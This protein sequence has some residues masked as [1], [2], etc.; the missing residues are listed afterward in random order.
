MAAYE[1]DISCTSLVGSNLVG[2]EHRVVDWTGNLTSSNTQVPCGVVR[3]GKAANKASEIIYKG[4]CQAYVTLGANQSVAVGTK[5][6]CSANGCFEVAGA[7]TYVA[8]VSL[9]A[10]NTANNTHLLKVRVRP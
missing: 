9:E 10:N 4:T 3:H 1:Q 6:S 7:T 2:S 5:L 8:A